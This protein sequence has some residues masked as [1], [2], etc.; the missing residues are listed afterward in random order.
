MKAE[1]AREREEKA[2]A[3]IKK[4]LEQLPKTVLA[5]LQRVGRPREVYTALSAAF[6]ESA[7]DAD[8]T[9]APLTEEDALMEPLVTENRFY[10]SPAALIT[11]DDLFRECKL[12][13]LLGKAP[14]AAAKDSS[15]EE[16][17]DKEN[18][19]QQQTEQPSADERAQERNTMMVSLKSIVEAF[20]S[21]AYDSKGEEDCLKQHPLLENSGLKPNVIA[22]SVDKCDAIHSLRVALACLDSQPLWDAITANCKHAGPSV[23]PARRDTTLPVW[24]S[25]D[26]D[27]ILMRLVVRGYGQWKK[28]SQGRCVRPSF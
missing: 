12:E 20:L 17:G 1:K 8:A 24:W 3:A 21:V 13:S 28:I 15:K 19:D 27:I 5:A 7:A 25:P 18:A 11:W 10:R 23:V 26:C 16:E 6:T 2:A 4:K 9:V 22:E 14:S